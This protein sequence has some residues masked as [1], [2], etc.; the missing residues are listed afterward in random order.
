M[1]FLAGKQSAYEEYSGKLDKAGL[2]KTS[3]GLAWQA[4]GSQSLVQALE[5]DVPFAFSTLFRAKEVKAVAWKFNLPRGQSIKLSMDFNDKDSSLVFADIFEEVDLNNVGWFTSEDGSYSFESKKS[6]TYI[7]R[8]QPEL[9]AEGNLTLTVEKAP[10]YAVFPIYGK[11]ASSVQ[12]FWGAPRG[13]GARKHE[14][15]DIFAARGTPVLAP[16]D[17]VVSS[18]R[19]RGLGGKQVWLRDAER[20]FNLYFAHLD[21]Q[22]VSFGQRLKAGDTLGLVGNT[23]NARFTPP[24]L[25]FGIYSGG[26]FDPFPMVDNRNQKAEISDLNVDD[27]VLNIKGAKANFRNKPTT[28]SDVLN[29]L[30]NGNPVKVIGAQG[31]WYRVETPNLQ[32]GYIHTSLV[33]V[34]KSEALEA[35]DLWVWSN[36]FQN[37]SDSLLI[38][39]ELAMVGEFEGFAMLTDDFE[40]VYYS[41]VEK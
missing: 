12:S 41:R 24:H 6:Q 3:V 9:F 22:L 25:H 34:I 11:D 10:T 14:G 39:G 30:E 1:S 16:V 33:G 18:V 40:N 32:E 23:G 17:G 2:Y 37:P 38:N 5:S 13:G 19:D 28:K 27:F 20:G 8:I 21:S 29:T 31:S 26:A 4:S 36:P 35:K 7:L 15:I